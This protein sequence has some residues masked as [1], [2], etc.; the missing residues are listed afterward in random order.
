MLE[1]YMLDIGYSNNQIKIIKNIYPTSL[2]SC[3]TILYNLKNLYNYFHKNGINNK[4]FIYITVTTPNIISESIENIKQKIFE[5]N[6]FG[7]NKFESFDIIKNYPYILE[8]SNQ[9]IKNKFDKLTDIGF[10]KKEI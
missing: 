8:I 9:K 5:L 3:S 7:F 1:E 6:E 2:Y 4:E 10:S